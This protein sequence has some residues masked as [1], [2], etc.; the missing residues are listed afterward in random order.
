MTGELSGAW[1]LY[2]RTAAFVLTVLYLLGIVGHLWSPTYEWVLAHTASFLLLFGLATQS[3][4]FAAGGRRF[5]AW[6]VGVYVFTM[7]VEMAGVATGVVFGEY[8]YGNTLGWT[9]HGVPLVIGLNWV[10]ITNGAVCI[11]HRALP[12]R[13]GVGR[14]ARTVLLAAGLVAILDY[15]LEPVAM[16]LDYWQ[17]AGDRIPPR[18]YQAWVII[19]AIAAVCHPRLNRPTVELGTDGRLAALYLTLMAAFFLIMQIAWRSLGT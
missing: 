13:P 1:R 17:W 9:V 3:P 5:A 19:A 15:L 18:N 14:K 8:D 16:R 10:A 6:A 7:L 4:S 11:A 2:V 12:F